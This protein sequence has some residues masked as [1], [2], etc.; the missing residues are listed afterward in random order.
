MYTTL[1]FHSDKS[2]KLVKRMIFSLLSLFFLPFFFYIFIFTFSAVSIFPPV[3]PFLYFFRSRIFPF[4][5]FSLPH[6]QSYFI[7]SGWKKK[8]QKHRVHNRVFFHPI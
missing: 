2:T 8:V 4:F 6:C 3:F 5:F 7:H 1:V